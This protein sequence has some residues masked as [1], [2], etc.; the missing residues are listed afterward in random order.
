VSH[1]QRYL[2][3]EYGWY[4]LGL[5]LTVPVRVSRVSVMVSIVCYVS[6]VC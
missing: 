1:S 2:V 5:R 3:V 6:I 4:G